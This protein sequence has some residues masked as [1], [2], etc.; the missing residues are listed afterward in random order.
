MFGVLEMHDAQLGAVF[1]Q[2]IAGNTSSSA[3]C[4]YLPGVCNVPGGTAALEYEYTLRYPG[5]L[6]S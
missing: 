2:I 5:G 4:S 6:H 3:T 1:D